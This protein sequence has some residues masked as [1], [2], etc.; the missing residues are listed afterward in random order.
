ML[1]MRNSGN[2]TD[3]NLSIKFILALELNQ[4][5]SGACVKAKL[6]FQR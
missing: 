2:M 6:S 1:L 5:D 4:M 3:F